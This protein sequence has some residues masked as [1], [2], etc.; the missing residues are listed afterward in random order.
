VN[1]LA[2]LRAIH[3]EMEDAVRILGGSRIVALARVVA[4]L[5]KKGL[6]GSWI[7]VFIPAV[8]ELS[9]AIFLVAANTRVISVMLLDLS[10]DGNFET[11][12]ALGC[13]LLAATILIVVASYRMLGRDLLLKA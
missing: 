3:P 1:C 12:A 10:E 8:R 5:M 7:L 2:G 13:V 4:P 6:V 9:T 11:L